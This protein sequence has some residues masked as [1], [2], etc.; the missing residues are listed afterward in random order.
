M[1]ILIG[2]DKSGFVLKEGIK[3]LLE[4]QGHEVRDMGTTDVEKPLRFV[5]VAPGVA[6]AV[7]KGEAERAI[8]I[9]GTGMGMTQVASMHKGVFAACCESVYAAKMCRAV[10]NSN[11]LCMGAWIVGYE[12][13][14]E[15]VK[16]F[17]ETEHTQGLEPWRQEF[18]KKA[19]G[20]VLAIDNRPQ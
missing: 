7:S 6:S 4:E 14:V 15:M 9:C 19:L 10:N 11:I 2:S 8:L 16:V 5:D 12:M 18:L 3:A 1:K 13:A 17:L 20:D